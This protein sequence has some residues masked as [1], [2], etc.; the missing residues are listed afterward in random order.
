MADLNR[1]KVERV[2][3]RFMDEGWEQFVR[4]REERHNVLL[5]MH[6]GVSMHAIDLTAQGVSAREY[7]D[8][9][10]QLYWPDE[11][12]T[13]PTD[14]PNYPSWLLPG[15]ATRALCSTGGKKHIDLSTVLQPVEIAQELTYL[16]KQERKALLTRSQAVVEVVSALREYR[17]LVRELLLSRS[18]GVCSQMALAK[19]EFLIAEVEA[20]HGPE[21]DD[22]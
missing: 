17:R 5:F 12:P 3:G 14:D 1:K 11:T 9:Y 8:A 15:D 20:G 13:W 22:G 16:Q 21:D 18:D 19:V 6:P 10:A 7:L 2:T 4:A